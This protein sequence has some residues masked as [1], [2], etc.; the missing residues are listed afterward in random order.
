M[1]VP[2]AAPGPADQ[3]AGGDGLARRHERLDVPVPEVAS[4]HEAANATRGREEDRP[5]LDRIDAVC[6][7]GRRARFGCVVTHRDIDPVVID[8]ALLRIRARV[9]KGT[10]D[11]M[12]LVVRPHRPAA[13]FVVIGLR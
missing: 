5:A 3:L 7:P 6:A 11:R 8:G 10:P 4:V 12:L 1:D 9:E 2:V 13:P